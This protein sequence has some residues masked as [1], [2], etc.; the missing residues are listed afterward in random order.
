MKAM[1]TLVVACFLTSSVEAQPPAQA[2]QVTPRQFLDAI[3][4]SLARS[5]MAIKAMNQ[6]ANDPSL[7][8]R[9]TANQNASIEL[10]IAASNIQRFT[11]VQDENVRAST[12]GSIDAYGLMRKSLAIQL[13][14]YEK[15]DAAKSPDDLAG[16]RRQISDAKVS[17]QQASRV[18]VDA[19]TLAF[20][21]SVAPDP[22]DPANHIALNMT[23]AQKAQLVKALELRFG[24]A[25]RKKA[26]DD[27]GPMQA[28]KALLTN[29]DKQWR[30]AK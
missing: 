16:I 17:Y 1:S 25:L 15:V 9:M 30:H 27:T 23:A 5:H 12:S 21:S 7:V 8:E 2:V 22:Q 4:E 19:T 14:L 24:P 28:A 29:L 11:S 20:M 3:I 18:L 26:D 13:A 10:D 6:K